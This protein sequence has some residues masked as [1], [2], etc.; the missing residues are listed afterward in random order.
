MNK[1]FVLQIQ[2][3]HFRTE[4]HLSNVALIFLHICV[5]VLLVVSVRLFLPVKLHKIRIV[6]ELIQ[7]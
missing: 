4:I 3:K 1:Y 5:S 6:T 7:I 2:I